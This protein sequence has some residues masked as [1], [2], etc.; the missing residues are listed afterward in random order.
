M[1]LIVNIYIYVYIWLVVTGTW[2]HEFYKCSHISVGNRVILIDELIYFSEG[3]LNHQPYIYIYIIDIQILWTIYYN[4]PRM[5][6]QLP[7]G[8][9]VQWS[10][11]DGWS[12]P[13]GWIVAFSPPGH[14]KA[15]IPQ[16]VWWVQPGESRCFLIFC[17]FWWE[18]GSYQPV[19]EFNV[20][21]LKPDAPYLFYGK[22]NTLW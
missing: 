18:S 19:T 15:I 16:D 11:A 8:I 4:F 20:G 7:H 1:I 3:W 6:Y 17:E 5:I 2:E 21:K 9:M 13:D 22:V 14:E 10:F 12:S